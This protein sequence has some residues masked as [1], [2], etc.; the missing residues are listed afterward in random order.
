MLKR[1]A[2]LLLGIGLIGLGVLLFV[3]PGGHVSLQWLAKLWPIF[4]ILAGLVQ[5]A[6]HLIDRHP[7]SPVA[8]M[9]IAAVGGIVLAANL[10][11]DRSFLL[12]FGRYWFWLLLAYIT[13]RVLRQY[14]HRTSDGKRIAAFSAGAIFVMI[15]LVGGGLGA[16][17]L[18][19]HKT[20]LNG[21]EWKLSRFGLFAGEFTVE[22][23]PALALP[24]SPA[25][26]LLISNFRGNIEISAGAQPNASARLVK[27]IRA[28]DQNE[29]NQTAKSIHLQTAVTGK[30]LQL[31]VSA[32][33]VQNDFNNTLIISLPTAATGAASGAMGGVEIVKAGGSVKLD[34]LR[35]DQ[36]I[37]DSDRIEVR[38]NAGRVTIE[39]PRSVELGQIQGEVNVMGARGNL[40][41]REIKGAI[42]L[43]AR[44]GNV[45]I[46]QSSGPV[47]ARV[48]DVRLTINELNKDLAKDSSLPAGQPI[49]RLANAGNSRIN[50][51]Q[52]KGA[53]SINAERCRIEAENI[54]GDLTIKNSSEPIQVNRL[55]GALKINAENSTV[56]IEEVKGAT[57]IETTRDVTVRGFR[58]A[59][60][61]TTSAGAI[62]LSTDEKLA[63]NIR[64]TSERGRIHVSLPE[65]G[66]FK[67][68]AS[69]DSGQV[70]LRGFDGLSVARR[71]RQVITEYNASPNSPSVVLRSS[72]GDVELSSSGSALASRDDQDDGEK[73]P[74]ESK[75]APTP[76]KP[77]AKPVVKPVAKPVAKLMEK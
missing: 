19:T 54:I 68:D 35:G 39:N 72:R 55:N 70:K 30:N 44:G 18:A 32:E 60:S 6:G 66:G 63:G 23:E 43:D 34:G 51:Q 50:L 42:T 76:P 75:P 40:E 4:L 12:L 74:E 77:P 16:N 7:R 61:V 24:I 21:V 48:S 41:L 49:V 25:Q 15:L 5:V 1:L 27:R 9:M 45:T 47:Q 71:Q 73:P 36:I 17:Y 67:L 58:G 22:D 33:G 14:T 8:G 37:R 13:G 64:A 65:G 59:L 3:A 29:A 57:E 52:I 46:E 38:N 10:R 53:V 62:N 2:T 31:N 26:R 28:N 11:G 20:Y 69:A 56:G